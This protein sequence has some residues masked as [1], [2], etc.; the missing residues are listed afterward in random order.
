MW[1][2]RNPG[3]SGPGGCQSKDGYSTL[4]ALAE[5]DDAFSNR[6]ILLADSEDGKPLPENA[7]PMRIVAPGD[8]R[9]ARWARMVTSIELVH[10]PEKAPLKP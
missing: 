7:G 8:K 6:T 3:P 10:I 1:Y 4:F 5:F 9:A 2:L